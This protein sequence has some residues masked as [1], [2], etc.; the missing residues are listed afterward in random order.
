MT[1]NRFPSALTRA[2]NL[3]GPVGTRRK[4]P[5]AAE[6]AMMTAQQFKEY[7]QR[8]GTWQGADQ[9]AISSMENPESRSRGR[10]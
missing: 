8:Q 3:L 7:A 2:N 4:G 6:V 1:N 9:E 10:Y 5:S